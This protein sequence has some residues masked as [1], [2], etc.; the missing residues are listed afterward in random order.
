MTTNIYKIPPQSI[1]TEESIIASCLLGYTEKAANII[2]PEDFYRSAHQKIFKAILELHK[3]NEPI[4]LN[5]VGNFLRDSGTL[6]ECGGVTY[7]ANIIDTVPIAANVEHYCNILKEKATLR[8]LIEKCNNIVMGCYDFQPDVSLFIEQSQNDISSVVLETKSKIST[9][10]ELSEE[11]SDRYQYLFDNKNK[12]TGLSSGFY[13]L[14]WFTC[15]FQKTDFI[16][17]AARP[18]M[19]KTAL[20]L[21]IAGNIAKE[22]NPVL[23]FSHEMSKHQLFDRQ[24]SSKSEVNLQKFR[25]GRFTQEDWAALNKSQSD[26]YNWPV[27]IEDSSA[28]HYSKIRNIAYSAI[29]KHGIKIII[30]DYLQL[31]KGDKESTRDREIAGISSSMK[32]M[33]KDFNIPIIVLSQLNR[34]LENRGVDKK[35]PILADLRDSGTLEQDSD[36]IMFLYRPAVYGEKEPYEGYAEL[37]IAKHRNGPTGM[38]NLIWE[39]KYTRFKNVERKNE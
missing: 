34:A 8:R 36:L 26:V 31:I 20:C 14:D 32:S 17:L 18:S 9:Y 16:I 10:R 37:S 22:G 24:I 19:G 4:D 12:I 27:F 25:S 2:I 30:I 6:E 5:T 23:I 35:R 15:G 13:D 11:A 38:I 7:L 28:L 33:A 1:E 39:E 29:K 21:N 3:K